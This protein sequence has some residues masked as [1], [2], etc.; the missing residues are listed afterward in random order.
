MAKGSDRVQGEGGDNV[1]DIFYDIG[2]WLGQLLF[3]SSYPKKATMDNY[4]SIYAE[5]VARG[6][7]VDWLDNEYIEERLSK[8]EYERRLLDI[9]DPRIPSL[10][11]FYG[12]SV[13][14]VRRR[15]ARDGALISF[16]LGK[17]ILIP[18]APP[19]P[20]DFMASSRKPTYDPS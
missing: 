18:A 14:D 13:T 20:K 8:Y 6:S 3:P 15:I 1:K 9:D 10:A 7:L 16:A 5:V 17:T 4:P 12:E 2:A 11:A 19:M